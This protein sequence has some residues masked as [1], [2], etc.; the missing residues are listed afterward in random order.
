MFGPERSLSLMISSFKCELCLRESKSGAAPKIVI[1]A[2]E[3]MSLV[4]T[5]EFSSNIPDNLIK[6]ASQTLF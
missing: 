4:K 6:P 5:Q 2:W 1:F 3:T